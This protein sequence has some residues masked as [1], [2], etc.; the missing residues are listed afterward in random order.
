[1][2]RNRIGL[3]IEGFE[4]WSESLEKAGGAIQKVTEECLKTAQEMITKE[5]R[6]DMK[7]HHR[8]GRTELSISE[9]PVKWE[10]TCASVPVGFDINKGGL[11]SVFLMYGTPRIKKDV[12][13]YNDVYGG[14]MKKKIAERQEEIFKSEMS[15]LMEG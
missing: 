2:G 4:E 15:K 11:A 10:G 3:Q 1:M 13:L 12:K 7:K 5:L 9:D 6:K 8:T 14:K